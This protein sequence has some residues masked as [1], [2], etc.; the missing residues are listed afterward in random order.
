MMNIVHRRL[1]PEPSPGQLLIHMSSNTA[2]HKAVITSIQRYT[3]ARG[4]LKE[5]KRLRSI[6]FYRS[7]DSIALLKQG[8]SAAAFD[9]TSR[10]LKG[11]L[12]KHATG[13]EFHSCLP[14]R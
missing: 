9:E 3:L 11:I 14:A 6:W 1:S 13:R 10:I 2:L 12:C 4:Q 8:M 7:A 5:T